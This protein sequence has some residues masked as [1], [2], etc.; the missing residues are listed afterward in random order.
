MATENNTS[1]IN[2]FGKGMN[3]DLSYSNIQQGQYLYAENL[4][5]YSLNQANESVAGN[6]Y[7]EMRVI[8]GSQIQFSGHTFDI[9]GGT[10]V[11][12][13]SKIKA[14]CSIR[15]IAVVIIE[16]SDKNWAIVRFQNSESN[17][18]LAENPKII[19][20]SGDSSHPTSNRQQL[21]GN[22][23]SVVM[24]WETDENVKLYIAD[25]VHFIT[26]FNVAPANDTYNK[27]Q[28]YNA[29]IF[30]SF[31][32]VELRPIIFC[33]LVEG[34]L[35][36]GTVQYSY[37]FYNKRGSYSRVSA[38]TKLIPLGFNNM[39]ASGANQVRGA[40]GTENVYQGVRMRIPVYDWNEDFPMSHLNIYRIHHQQNGQEPKISLI[41]D[42]RVNTTLQG[43]GYYIDYTDY[44]RE[45]LQDLSVD[46][47]NG[48][49]GLYIIPK[50]I[51]SKN[52]RLFAAN[53]K[54]DQSSMDKIAKLF[55][56]RAF[57]V[58][59]DNKVNVDGE[60]IDY[61]DF[62]AKID[63]YSDT[64][65]CF[66]TYNNINKH[67]KA[68]DN[69]VCKLMPHING[70]NSTYSENDGFYYGGAGRYVKWKF[71][72]TQIAA[73]II[74][75]SNTTNYMTDNN[76]TKGS[77]GNYVGRVAQGMS[78]AFTA[79]ISPMYVYKY[80]TLSD[81]EEWIN[82]V[83]ETGSV[84]MRKVYDTS[85]VNNVSTS[86]TYSNPFV[87]YALK[88]LRRD[89]LYR[90]GIILY[91]QRGESTS[92]LW[93]ADIRTPSV[94]E[95]CFSAYSSQNTNYPSWQ[96]TS[97]VLGVVFNVDID[98]FNEKLKT[99]LDDDYDNYK[100][101]SYEI[102]RCHRSDSDI[103]TVAQGVIAR[104]IQCTKNSINAD[105]TID[106]TYTPTG[107]L[108]TQQFWT[109]CMWVSRNHN[110]KA[111]SELT[112]SGYTEYYKFNME[113]DN[114]E[115]HDFYQFICP[116]NTYSPDYMKQLYAN[117]NLEIRPV[118][119]VFGQ[120]AKQ[121]LS[122]PDA[123]YEEKAPN[124]VHR[125]KNIEGSA[126]AD[127][128]QSTSIASPM[129]CQ[130][131][132]STAIQG[133]SLALPELIKIG[134]E[135]VPV[136]IYYNP[137]VSHVWAHTMYGYD[138][139]YLKQAQLSILWQ[140]GSRN[141]MS[142]YQLS[143]VFRNA[144][145]GKSILD[146]SVVGNRYADNR[147]TY[148]TWGDVNCPNSTYYGIKYGYTFRKAG[149]DSFG[150]NDDINTNPFGYSKLYESSDR[151][152]VRT[153]DIPEGS[154]E[155]QRQ[156]IQV[157]GRADNIAYYDLDDLD[158]A[159]S[160]EY[161][162]VTES[163]SWDSLYNSTTN[164]DSKTYSAK[165]I[166]NSVICGTNT[167]CNVITSG[168]YNNA[169]YI[170][171][172]GQKGI[173]SN[174]NDNI[175]D[176]EYPKNALV[177]CG[178]TTGL[179]QLS[180]SVKDNI[181]YKNYATDEVSTILNRTVRADDLP[182]YKDENG[183]YYTG[184]IGVMQYSLEHAIAAN[185]AYD[186][187]DSHRDY[188][189]NLYNTK[190]FRN[191]IAGTYLCNLRQRTTPY[192]GYTYSDRNL[193]TYVSYG[194]VQYDTNKPLYVFDGDCFIDV[195]EYTSCHK[196]YDKNINISV[197]ANLNYAIPVETSINLAYTS[198]HTF[199]RNCTKQAVC[200]IQEQLGNVNDY[201]TQTKPQYEY[202]TVYSVQPQVDKKEAADLSEDSNTLYDVDY[203]C[204][205]SELKTNN[206]NYDSWQ[207][208]KP[209]NY[210]DVDDRYGEITNLRTFNDQ[211]LFWQESATGVFS[212]NERTSITDDSGKPLIL[213][214]GGVLNRYDYYD[215]TAGMHKE[216]YCDA[217][218]QSSIY[219]YDAHN[220]ELKTLSGNGVVEMNKMYGTQNLMHQSAGIDAPELFYDKKYD[221]LVSRVLL[222]DG[223][224]TS[225]A[226]SDIAKA[227]TSVYNISFDNSVTFQDRTYL[228]NVEKGKLQI[229]L[230]NNT[231][232]D[233][234]LPTML[235][236]VVN[237]EPYTVKVFDNQELV[238]SDR[239]ASNPFASN[240]AWTWSTDL[241]KETGVTKLQMT[242]REGTFKYAVPRYNNASY[243][244]RLRGKHMICKIVD[245]KPDYSVALS[246]V[247]TK[248]RR[249][250]N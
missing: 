60:K 70:D 244:D 236:Y 185:H 145:L 19:F 223:A 137:A 200:Q 218:S 224:R 139:E 138:G 158:D 50:V 67:Y 81:T 102:V 143:P 212:V 51:E 62:I 168:T 112:G 111:E 9:E 44:G 180:S 88:S 93:I 58:N 177:G 48:L 225:L 239:T 226:Y 55:D 240:H 43:D 188:V 161:A 97:N 208:F 79:S 90:Y 63:S 156:N 211:L 24:T 105:V 34:S 192:G 197:T 151:L 36:G 46:E 120:A 122:I 11:F 190:L 181:L 235:Q 23:V 12:E 133:H 205:Y 183:A 169:Q 7:G 108:T 29:D 140:Q 141:A 53:I 85:L 71:T 49:S 179:I 69:T 234:V 216:Q 30:Q 155:G 207:V 61:N 113:A 148:I 157:F 101:T 241:Y 195:F 173:F 92:V 37:R 74:R 184:I 124:G 146:G 25:G 215:R 159:Y 201:Y 210:I 99:E 191:S 127:T 4:R 42:G 230:W 118:K 54:D 214:E 3:T 125:N 170:S 237:S 228:T 100:I 135:N 233:N 64:K 204:Y 94:N 114:F 80:K 209:A 250:C 219:W 147:S 129:F 52:D 22:K 132:V 116:E 142:Y 66:D 91:N 249:S 15:D 45:S 149:T 131:Y 128:W 229:E 115:N 174:D 232:H 136:D 163:P 33:G 166:N 20:L 38:P 121:V 165:Y 134:D 164:G 73:D 75:N 160:V 194:D 199:S 82:D 221:E 187:Y 198:G 16:D 95:E 123:T 72:I 176:G 196:Y 96:L 27:K 150:N 103:Q 246:Y 21:G 202:N 32:P 5:N 83:E 175:F 231:N 47:Y 178:G 227:F 107:T 68:S 247:I 1:F 26:M 31:K 14:A 13:V 6:S 59:V 171:T 76:Y 110:E 126:Y 77:E 222:Q 213:G 182:I 248:F 154:T 84:D 193:N 8:E 89:E 106:K 56:A 104:P 245:Y 18:T 220:N 28:F 65:D 206:E 98:K 78:D 167:F 2:S 186:G 130:D 203:R 86:P 39:S 242:D 144:A 40:L 162:T 10:I 109:G 117:S 17:T 119:Y 57:R 41:Y 153:Y 217:C 152:L 238:T 189:D 87:S 35:T 243:G 172:D